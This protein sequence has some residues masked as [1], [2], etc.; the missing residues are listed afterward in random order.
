MDEVHAEAYAEETS[1]EPVAA[2]WPG[3]WVLLSGL[4]SSGLTLGL[5]AMISSRW[6]DVQI[7]GWYWL[8]IVPIGAIL[9]GIAA[10]SG[11]GIASWL[12][13]AKIGKQLLL[14]VILLQVCSYA[15]AQYEEYKSARPQLAA[16]GMDMSFAEYFDATTRSITFRPRDGKPGAEMGIWG[17]AFRILEVVGFALGGLV[18][19][20]AMMVKPYCDDC[21]SYMKTTKQGV[22]P[23]GMAPRKIRSRDHEGQAEYQRE[24]A[25]TLAEGREL[26][27]RLGQWVA[28]GDSEAIAQCLEQHRG[29]AKQIE[30]Q[31]ARTRVVLEHCPRCDRGHLVATL[32]A[33][34]AKEET[35]LSKQKWPA[36]AETV[37]ALLGKP[38]G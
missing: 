17:Y 26:I 33:G 11:Y 6:P 29:E 36:S 2:R 4:A 38:A 31:T 24:V 34:H 15:L 21:R 27:E 23:A 9:V 19:P 20:A 8:F 13:N 14:I 32:V 28:A 37:L 3:M 1:A 5:L 22:L 30:K 16:M 12:T 10:G 7:M 35:E 18:V 25:E